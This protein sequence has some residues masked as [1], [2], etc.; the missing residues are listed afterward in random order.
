MVAGE[1]GEL[2]DSLG[3]RLMGYQAF[4]QLPAPQVAIIGV[5]R[6]GHVNAPGQAGGRAPWRARELQSRMSGCMAERAFLAQSTR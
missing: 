1:A 2:G 3:T 6:G 5:V 4:G